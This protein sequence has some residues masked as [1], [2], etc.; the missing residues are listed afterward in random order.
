MKL[1][2]F[3]TLS[4]AIIGACTPLPA[5]EPQAGADVYHGIR[6]A[7][8][9]E[10]VQIFGRSFEDFLA[11]EKS[12]R[13]GLPSSIFKRATIPICQT[14]INSPYDG[15]INNAINYLANLPSGTRCGNNQTPPK[16]VIMKQSGS[17]KLG[18]CGPTSTSIPCSTV[19][20]YLR[21]IRN[22]C[23]DGYQ[24]FGG[25]LIYVAAG[26]QGLNENLAN[27]VYINTQ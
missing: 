3:A 19:V 9:E 4:L 14:T 18:F 22:T 16:C 24:V 23:L 6:A 1:Q 25:S 8:P 13:A 20:N 11:T 2:L 7:T 5:A 21:G 27:Y 15:D 10:V 26:Y 17:A 12:K